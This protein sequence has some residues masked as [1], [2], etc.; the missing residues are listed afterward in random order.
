MDPT[1]KMLF[2]E[3]DNFENGIASWLVDAGSS[4]TTSV[5]LTTDT[6]VSWNYQKSMLI[7]GKATG[8]YYV[9]GVQKDVASDVF[10]WTSPDYKALNML[11]KANGQVGDRLNVKIQETDGDIW[12]FTQYIGDLNTWTYLGLLLDRFTRVGS[13][14][15]GTKE[16]NKTQFIRIELQSA[17]ST[18]NVSLYIDNINVSTSNISGDTDG[19]GIPNWFEVSNNLNASIANT[20]DTD[21][22]GWSDLAEYAARTNPSQWTP[23]FPLIDN[24]ERVGYTWL[25][26]GISATRSTQVGFPTSSLLVNGI[27]TNYFGG[28]VGAYIYNPL[29]TLPSVYKS[30]TMLIN[31]KNGNIGDKLELQFQDK[32]GDAYAF[33]QVLITADWKYYTI[34]LDRLV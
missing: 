2:P 33:T 21:G 17:T 29:N 25:A 10:N 8:N 31:N 30:L 6:T 23:H 22:D 11:I 1:K 13:T 9:G 12:Q 26:D 18:G 4:V 32:D 20:G 34:V 27:A 5:A 16:F 19:D 3:I 14:G 15:N 7:S 24:F 28:F